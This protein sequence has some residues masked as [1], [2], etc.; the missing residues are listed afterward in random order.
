VLAN[1]IRNAVEGHRAKRAVEASERRLRGVYERVTDGVLAMNADWEYTYVNE[2]AAR[3]VG[4]S[5]EELRGSTVWDAFPGLVDT[6]FEEA[7]RRAMETQETTS[8]EA[9]YGP[10]DIWANVT[11]YPDEDGISV[12][13]RDV[14]E[15]KQR[16]RE[17]ERTIEFL[18]TLY[19]V[20]T[21][22]GLSPRE[23]ITQLLEVGPEQLGLPYGHLT[24]IEVDEGRPGGGTQ[25]VVEASG[26]H[27]LLQPGDSC[28][29]SRSYC[30]NTIESD[31]LF[32][33]QNALDAGWIDDPA[34][35]AFDL[36]CY[37]GTKVSVDGELYG[38]VFFASAEPRE[39]PFTEAER[40]FVRLMSQLVAYELER[41][42]GEL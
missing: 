25:T 35:V 39:E 30:R 28:P 37:I 17:R 6:P 38:T 19:D 18:Q 3:I 7:L 41:V 5:R 27:E 42:G 33:V 36:G 20:A 22:A 14:T 40:T 1:R 16:E 13:F 8:V 9:Y 11:V 31:D 34:Y 29:L 21:D 26:D 10:Y 23:K 24:R 4:R 2:A 15:R 32:V 12:Y